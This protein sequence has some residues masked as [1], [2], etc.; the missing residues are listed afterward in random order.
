MIGPDFKA[1]LARSSTGYG[2]RVVRHLN[3]NLIGRGCSITVPDRLGLGFAG[4]Y[5]TPTGFDVFSAVINQDFAAACKRLLLRRCAPFL[6]QTVFTAS[7]P[8][9]DL[10]A[11]TRHRSATGHGSYESCT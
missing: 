7:N 4:K 11:V 2:V 9:L 1:G 10:A 5:R 8:R 3:H 6:F